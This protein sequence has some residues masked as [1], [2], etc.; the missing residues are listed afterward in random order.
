MKMT[1][2]IMTVMVML[3]L[4]MTMTVMIMMAVIIM[5]MLMTIMTVMLIMLLDENHRGG[6]VDSHLWP[7]VPEALL[8]HRRHS[9]RHLPHRG[10]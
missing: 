9:Y 4:L 10:S 2:I 5:I 7:A 8:L 3:M 1:D 6:L